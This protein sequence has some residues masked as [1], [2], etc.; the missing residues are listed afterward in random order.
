M[1][2]QRPILELINSEFG[3]SFPDVSTYSPLT[4]AY[5]GDA[6]FDLVVRTLLVEQA[7]I[8][9]KKLHKKASEIVKASSQAQIILAIEDILTE[10]ELSI[11]KRGR[12]AKSN[13]VAKNAD[14]R[15]Y[16]NATGFEALFG[17]L[18]LSKHLDRALELMKLGM[19]RTGIS[20][21][22]I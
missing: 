5:I 14:I 1:V 17:Y 13:S 8:Q 11:F 18:Y 6:I 21:L 15:D 7:N 10:E 2:E 4:L 9:V 20:I 16:R 19:E 22:S 12:N 3:Q